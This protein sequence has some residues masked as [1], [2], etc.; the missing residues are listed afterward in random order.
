M[1]Q[2]AIR[3]ATEVVR[4]TTSATIH[5]DPT[6]WYAIGGVGAPFLHDARM[7]LVQNFTNA[8]LWI[9]D[10]PV[11]GFEKFPIASRSYLLFDFASNRTDQ[12]KSLSVAKGTQWYTSGIE[13]PT[14]G[15]IYLTVFYGEI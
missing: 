1:A 5:V 6:L 12:G 4:E 7:V 15:S 11:D 10:I 2:L 13:D 8:D 3:V 9:S 14:T